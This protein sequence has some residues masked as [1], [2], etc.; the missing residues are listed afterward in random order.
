[1]YIA[2]T[3]DVTGFHM[4]LYQ[5]IL[6]DLVALKQS[7]YGADIYLGADS[8]DYQELSIFALKMYDTLLAVQQ[9]YNSRS[10]VTATGIALDTVV[11]INGLLRQAASYSTVDLLIVGVAGTTI[12]NGMVQDTANQF[13]NLPA[14]VVI[15][16]IGYIIVTAT[17]AD[18]G[19]IQ[20]IAGTVT[21]ISTPQ[22]GWTSVTNLAA[23]SEGVDAETDTELR[24]RQALS[25]EIPSVTPLDGIVGAVAS[26][27]GITRYKGYDND[28][29]TTNS[30]GV[31]AHTICVV[32]EG[33]DSTE[34]ATAIANKKAP[35][36][37]TYG[38]TS[39][40][41]YDLHG[42]AHTMNFYRAASITVNVHITIHALAGYSV[43]VGIKIKTAIAEYINSLIIG[44]DVHVNTLIAAASLWDT[45]DAAT[46]SITVLLIGKTGASPAYTANDIVI[47]FNEVAVCSTGSSPDNIW[48]SAT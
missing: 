46:F 35:G 38:T 14:S 5:D 26:V 40:V 39:I 21:T 43:S 42:N 33:G 22:V 36:I 10:P 1:M 29:N 47:A 28:T 30:D 31:P 25:T 13:W 27:A 37:G 4:P 9:A 34:I 11:K 48:L 20:A 19:A 15:A 6:D 3:I 8:T 16:P 45:A 24:F 12:T 41:T 18:S 32:V 23:A 17:A 44:D 7:I 2:P